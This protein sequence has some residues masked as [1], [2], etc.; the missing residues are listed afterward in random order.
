MVERGKLFVEFDWTSEVD[1]IAA[2]D[3]FPAY[4]AGC[5]YLLWCCFC[6]AVEVSMVSIGGEEGNGSTLHRRVVIEQSRRMHHQHSLVK[7]SSIRRCYGKASANH[8][9][10]ALALQ[11]AEH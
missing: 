5:V 2:G 9:L 1:D 3:V 11:I 8:R 4:I 10:P 7:E 6:C